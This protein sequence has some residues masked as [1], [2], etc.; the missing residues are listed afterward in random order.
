MKNRLTTNK[1]TMI[2]LM[3]A[4]SYVA[5]T[6]LSIQIPTPAGM[7]SFHLGNVFCVL[8]ALIT[9]GIS[10]GLAGAIGMGIGD[11][12]N[13]VYI[14]TLPKTL[15]LKFF[16]G[17]ITGSLAHKFFRIKEKE[18]KDL[19]L[20]V[21]L[22]AGGGMFF[23]IIGEPLV[24]Y[25][26]YDLIL[27]NSTKAASYLTAAKWITTSVNGVLSIIISTLLYLALARRLN[28]KK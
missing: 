25:I 23:N 13:P 11:L 22:S 10:G 14:I 5:F 28:L 3:A 27:S 15:F 24:S 8:A 16:I 21:L 1:L 18:G 19:V 9:D 20:P 4:L 7:T 6:Y 17:F 12:F 26:Y 2:A